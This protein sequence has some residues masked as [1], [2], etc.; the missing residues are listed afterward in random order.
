MTLPAPETLTLLLS[1]IAPGTSIQAIE[2]LHL[3]FA[4]RSFRI[5]VR[6]PDTTHQQVYIVK[7]Y[8]VDRQ[9]VFGQDAARRASIEHA[10][11]SLLQSTDIPCPRPVLADLVGALLGSPVVV[12]PQL[13]G[14]HLLA[15]PANH[16]WAD[17]AATVAALLARIHQ[18]ACP[19]A[20]T[21]SLPGATTQATW[22]L[23]TGSLPDY[24]RA[25]PDGASIWQVIQ[26]ELPTI[27]PSEPVLV[28][29]D[30]WSGNILWDNGQVSGLLDWENAAFGERGFDVAYCRMEMMLEGMDEAAELFLQTYERMMGQPVV[31]LALCELAVAVQP[32]W[33]RAPFLTT[34]PYQER[35]RRFVANANQRV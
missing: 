6:R 9:N 2:P 29:G 15:H 31:N 33:Q 30:Y 3:G 35:F 5:T 23:V 12:T 28:H 4:N 17:R 34:A 24:M 7:R 27:K 19:D 14:S 25:Y 8:P 10:V 20:L 22:F 21:T 18:L 32:M 16:L 11:L 26:R 13:P 1:H